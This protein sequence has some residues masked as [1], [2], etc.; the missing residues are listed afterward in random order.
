M[1]EHKQSLFLQNSKEMISSF[2]LNAN[3]VHHISKHRLVIRAKQVVVIVVHIAKFFTNEQDILFEGDTW[4]LKNN[5][6]Q[7]QFQLPYGKTPI[8]K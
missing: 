5:N 3:Q 1:G 6:Y 8:F 7:C 4:K 2:L